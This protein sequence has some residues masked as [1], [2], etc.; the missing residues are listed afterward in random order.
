MKITLRKR[1]VVA[2]GLS[3]CNFK[4]FYKTKDTKKDFKAI[5]KPNAESIYKT[6]QA[7]KSVFSKMFN[8]DCH[9]NPCGFSLAMTECNP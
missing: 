4:A 8:M 1:E 7:I 6:N 2:D 9:E 3:G 5:Q